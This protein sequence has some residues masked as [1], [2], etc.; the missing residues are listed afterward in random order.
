[1][2]RA[3]SKKLKDLKRKEVYEGQKALKRKQSEKAHGILINYS[4]RDEDIVIGEICFTKETEP[5]VC[6]KLKEAFGFI[7]TCVTNHVFGEVLNFRG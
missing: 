5:I 1:M 7:P 4:F 2:G 3:K 6:D